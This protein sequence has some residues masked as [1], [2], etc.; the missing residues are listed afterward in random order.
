MADLSGMLDEYLQQ[1]GGAQGAAAQAGVTPASLPVQSSQAPSPNASVPA[2][3]NFDDYLMAS[4]P[5]SDPNNPP[6]DPSQTVTVTAHKP[7]QALQTNYDN[8]SDLQ[9]I[10]AV[11]QKQAA[12]GLGNNDPSANPGIWGLLPQGMQHGTLRNI[13]GALGDA[14]LIS[15]GHQPMYQQRL[16]REA[17]AN[18]QVGMQ[19]DPGAAASRVAATAAPGADTMANQMVEQQNQMKLRQQMMEQQNVYRQSV[20]DARRQS[21]L[22]QMQPKAGGLVQGAKDSTDY[23]Q[24]YALADAMAKRVDPN[25]NATEAFGLPLPEA[26]TPGSTDTVG[27]T[28]GQVMHN[29]TSNAS[30]QERATA[31]ANRN[32]VTMR[33]QNMGAY[34]SRYRTDATTP[35]QLRALQNKQN[36]GQTLTPAEQAI[37]ERG[38]H[39]SA[40]RTG[41][42][43]PA[44]LRVG[45]T[46]ATNALPTISNPADAQKLHSGTHFIYQGKEYF[47]H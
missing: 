2:A 47:R 44:G 32:A 8:T 10:Q 27:A 6:I 31:A 28:T 17:I 19:N 13:V 39:V 36:N 30:I 25:T 34:N 15:S 12:M 33:G 22:S 24:R 21:I 5:Y 11:Q 35:A 18:A 4:S 1:E 43:I 46:G 23:A 14:F 20:V 42:S 40:G 29:E 45:G 3:G 26:W 37:W 38:T 41:T 16:Q 7:T 9:A